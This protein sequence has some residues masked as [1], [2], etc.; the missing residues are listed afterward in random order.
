MAQTKA[1][2]DCRWRP[3]RWIRLEPAG[4]PPW[5]EGRCRRGRRITRPEAAG[6]RDW[7]AGASG[8]EGAAKRDTAPVAAI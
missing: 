1:C 4:G 6:C 5:H 7:L 2:R 3:R 8:P